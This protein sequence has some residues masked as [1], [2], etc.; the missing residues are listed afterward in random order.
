MIY[1]DLFVTLKIDC[2]G[3]KALTT[4]QKENIP[5]KVKKLVLQLKHVPQKKT[6]K[7]KSSKF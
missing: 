5:D 4:C 2:E 6:V 3:D 7:K 1:H